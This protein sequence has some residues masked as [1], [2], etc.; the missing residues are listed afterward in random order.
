MKGYLFPDSVAEIGYKLFPEELES[1]SNVYFHG[2]SKSSFDK[3]VAEGFKFINGAQSISFSL[4]SS[5]ALR[6]ACEKRG[7]NSPQGAVMAVT[8]PESFKHF[9]KEG[10]GMHVYTTDVQPKIVGYCIVP[11]SYL[12]I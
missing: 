2:T 6:Y 12:H 8:Y 3:I 4:R 11:E 5:L 7:L 9:H 10:F 1:N